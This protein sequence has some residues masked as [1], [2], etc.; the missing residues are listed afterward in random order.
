MNAIAWIG[1]SY[2]IFDL[3]QM[4][5]GVSE[6]FACHDA[7][8]FLVRGDRSCNSHITQIVSHYGYTYSRVGGYPHNEEEAMSY[9]LFQNG[10]L[11]NRK[12]AADYFNPKHEMLSRYLYD[13]MGWDDGKVLAAIAKVRAV[14]RMGLDAMVREVLNPAPSNVFQLFGEP[15]NKTVH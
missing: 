11:R 6:F 10:M 7:V 5:R 3:E 13:Y 9:D 8:T 4:D 14:D 2:K 12:G 15:A 1:T